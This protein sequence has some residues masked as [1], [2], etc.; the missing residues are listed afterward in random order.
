MAPTAF[1]VINACDSVDWLHTGFKRHQGRALDQCCAKQALLNEV[2]TMT[3]P[4]FAV[5]MLC[6]GMQVA[7]AMSGQARGGEALAEGGS[8]S[9]DL[10]TNDLMFVLDGSGS[11]SASDF[12]EGAPNRIDR[13][14]SALARILPEVAPY[15]KIG[16]VVYGPGKN[17]NSC[18]NV[19]L[20][21]KPV[22]NAAGLILD[23]A[24][25]VRPNGR[26]P[27][28]RSVDLALT[29]LGGS[30]GPV[31]IVVLTDGED[32]CGGDPC[33]LARQILADPRDVKVH[34]IGF[35]LPVSSE[36]EGAKCLATET[37][38]TFAIADT[39]DELTDALRQ[40]LSCARV[41]GLEK[42]FEKLVH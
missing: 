21:F 34:V 27:L 22:A 14:R 2:Q 31:E 39:T 24:E 18:R 40:T 4:K 37:G 32:T 19:E 5:A 30:Q 36:T 25:K 9:R 28:T 33:K 17:E 15:R 35:R 38:G 13:V 12:P 42:V 1:H 41:S 7:F 23:A 29:A 26:T 20:K 6:L 16:M 8:A 11:M 3:R 10:C